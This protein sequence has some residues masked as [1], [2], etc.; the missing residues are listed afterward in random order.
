MR[1]S[2][3]VNSFSHDAEMEAKDQLHSTVLVRTLRTAAHLSDIQP[4]CRLLRHRLLVA[5]ARAM[6]REVPQL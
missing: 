3:S 2:P 6:A 4:R 1:K 5:L